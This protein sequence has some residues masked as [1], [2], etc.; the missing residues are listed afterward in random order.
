MA[1][2]AATLNPETG[3]P[4][5]EKPPA[6]AAA[7][8]ALVCGALL[9]LGPVTAITALVAGFIALGKVKQDPRN[10]G[11]K[12][13]AMAG[14]GLGALNLVLSFFYAVYLVLSWV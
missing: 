2:Y 4:T 11:G 6:S 3:L 5:G 13:M 8:T 9:C 14:M 10:V 7:V 12:G 1:M